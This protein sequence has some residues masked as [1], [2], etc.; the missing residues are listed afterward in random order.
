MKCRREG[1]REGGRE[2]G[3]NGV[4]EGGKEIGR[5]KERE[6]W[7]EGSREGGRCN[8]QLSV[9]LPCHQSSG[10]HDLW[11]YKCKWDNEVYMYYNTCRLLWLHVNGITKCTRIG[12]YGY[13]KI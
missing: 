4:K 7:R 6:G 2:R 9:S 13:W 11:W 5:E 3:R 10:T 12:C 8:H 1:R